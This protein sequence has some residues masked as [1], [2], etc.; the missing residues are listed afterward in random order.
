[1][2][3]YP[4]ILPNVQSCPSGANASTTSNSYKNLSN[5]NWGGNFWMRL[6]IN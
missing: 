4:N 2:S 5:S 3:N 6:I 1:M